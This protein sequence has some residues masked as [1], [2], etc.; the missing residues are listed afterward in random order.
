MWIPRSDLDVFIHARPSVDLSLLWAKI[1]QRAFLLLL[2]CSLNL[3][4]EGILET[5]FMRVLLSSSIN[6][7]K[8]LLEMGHN[9]SV[10]HS[11]ETFKIL[12]RALDRPG[13]HSSSRGHLVRGECQVLIWLL[14]TKLNV[15]LCRRINTLFLTRI[16]GDR[17]YKS[18]RIGDWSRTGLV[19][20][21]ETREH[22]ILKIGGRLS[23]WQIRVVLN[24]LYFWNKNP[25]IFVMRYFMS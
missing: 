24:T 10:S 22:N 21:V 1:E 3:R 19:L 25:V 16:F 6:S 20:L 14:T 7:L 4:F 13:L 18:C 11:G 5:N 8:S 17:P 15:D 23:Y 9:L 2:W 12:G